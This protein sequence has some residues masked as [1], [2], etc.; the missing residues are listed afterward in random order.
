MNLNRF[1]LLSLGTY[2][3]CALWA[4]TGV[5]GDTD[6]SVAPSVPQTITLGM[7]SPQQLEDRAKELTATTTSTSTSTTET[8][9]TTVPFTVLAYYDPATHCSEWF[10]TAISVGWPN[11]T[12]TLE[13]LGRLL[14]KETRCQN[15]NYKHPR[16][17]GHDH[18]VAQI[19]EIHRR[20]VE[21]LFDGPMEESMSDPTLNLRFAYLLY[22]ELE[23]TGA[24]GW[25]AWSLC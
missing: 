17:N 23:E 4:I 18:G 16:F 14:W 22:S 13:K 1:I 10:S 3:L 21:Q 2:G 6:A 19:N 24:C 7:L 25:R 9:T 5:Q 12:E 15:V 11:N 20:Y 8:P